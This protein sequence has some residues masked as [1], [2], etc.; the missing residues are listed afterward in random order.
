MS[1]GQYE[2]NPPSTPEIGLS[3]GAD[4]AAGSG[5]IVAGEKLSVWSGLGNP[6]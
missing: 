2:M 3:R 1:H 4:S 5:A 6:D